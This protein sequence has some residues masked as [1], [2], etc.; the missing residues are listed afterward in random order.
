V[1]DDGRPATTVAVTAI[2]AVGTA[3]A[4]ALVLRE[5]SPTPGTRALVALDHA[6]FSTLGIIGC[7]L[8]L[9]V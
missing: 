6:A 4:A 8:A 5:H 9:M 2:G 1:H 3:A 7:V